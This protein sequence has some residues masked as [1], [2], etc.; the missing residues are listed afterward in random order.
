MAGAL[1]G[2]VV[3]ALTVLFWVFTPLQINGQ[4]LND[5]LYSMVPGVVFATLAI[6]LV[7][8][9]T[10]APGAIVDQHFNQLET[11]LNR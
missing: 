11:E 6:V 1:A 3:G 4:Q 9:L 8:L 10:K 7:S 2:M 5:F